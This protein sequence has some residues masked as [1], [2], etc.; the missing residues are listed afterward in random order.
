MACKMISLKWLNSKSSEFLQLGKKFHHNTQNGK[1]EMLLS[2]WGSGIH[3]VWTQMEGSCQS[4]RIG[5]SSGCTVVEQTGAEHRDGTPGLWARGVQ[6]RPGAPH[7]GQAGSHPASVMTGCHFCDVNWRIAQ[8]CRG[9]IGNQYLNIHAASTAAKTEN[10]LQIGIRAMRQG[11][12]TPEWTDIGKEMQWTHSRGLVE[13]GTCK[14]REMWTRPEEILLLLPLLLLLS[15]LPMLVK[16]FE[17][18]LIEQW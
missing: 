9:G 17:Q 2:N 8:V 11:R 16:G 18:F 1:I 12:S 10:F 6:S 15:I 7:T 14:E 3:L 4:C 5:S 13:F